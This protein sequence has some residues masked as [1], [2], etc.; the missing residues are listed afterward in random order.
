MDYPENRQKYIEVYL[1][2]SK[3]LQLNDK[4]INSVKKIS[5]NLWKDQVSH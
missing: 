2:F 5:P 4:L 1:K 3:K